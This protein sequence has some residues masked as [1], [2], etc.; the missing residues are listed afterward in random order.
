MMVG[1]CPVD[2]ESSLEFRAAFESAAAP[3]K[4][5]SPAVRTNRSDPLVVGSPSNIFELVAQ[6]QRFGKSA[7][8]HQD[9]VEVC[10]DTGPRREV[11]CRSVTGARG[12]QGFDRGRIATDGVLMHTQARGR[13]GHRQWVVEILRNALRHADTACG[14]S[15]ETHVVADQGHTEVGAQSS[16][17]GRQTLSEIQRAEDVVREFLEIGR[18]VDELQSPERL[19]DFLVR[20]TSNN[21]TPQ[22][23][24]ADP[25]PGLGHELARDPEPN[26][27]A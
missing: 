27:S 9:Q 21:G 3:A 1:D 2:L 11:T 22:H 8:R 25:V 24:P 7:L 23:A 15:A 19:Q 18:V 14:K 16:M 6:W 4:Y 26:G 5:V 17:G 10:G 13:D 12:P 20:R